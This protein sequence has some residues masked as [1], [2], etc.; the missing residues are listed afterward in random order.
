MVKWSRAWRAAGALLGWSIVWGFFSLIIT[1]VGFFLIASSLTPLLNYFGEFFNGFSA[2]GPSNVGNLPSISYG[3]IV[4]GFALIV[5]GC[6]IYVL[7]VVASFFKVNAEIT[8]EEVKKQIEKLGLTAALPDPIPREASIPTPLPK[9]A[10]LPGPIPRTGGAGITCQ[11]CGSP[12][13]YIQQYQRWYCDK[14][15]KYL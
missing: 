15:G 4:G 9:E 3:G 1:G 6:F 5:I 8:S 14:E 13:R 12:L 11:T 2:A 7:G 10:N